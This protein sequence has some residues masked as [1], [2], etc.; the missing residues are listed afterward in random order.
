MYIEKCKYNT[1]IKLLSY[2]YYNCMLLLYFN[3]FVNDKNLDKYL[4]TNVYNY[5]FILYF[6]DCP[7]C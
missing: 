1:V 5:I 3:N 6:V 7:M 2:M 4:N